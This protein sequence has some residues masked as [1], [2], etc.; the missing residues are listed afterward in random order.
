MQKQFKKL[1]IT[2]LLIR[3]PNYYGTVSLKGFCKLKDFDFIVN[4]LEFSKL[5]I[6]S[7]LM[8]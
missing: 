4:S 8:Q 6:E 2:D 3:K 5:N 7:W 1:T